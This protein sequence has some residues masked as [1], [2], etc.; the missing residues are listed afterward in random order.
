MPTD[1]REEGMNVEERL[2][3]CELIEAVIGADG[4]IADAERELLQRIVTRF[5]LPERPS[6]RPPPSD[7]GR[8]TTTL[9]SMALEDQPRVMALLVDAAVADGFVTPEERALLLASAATLGIEATALEDR[10][11][12]RL[13]SKSPGA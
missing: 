10:I 9:R 7:L 6:Q 5:G 1:R 3:V 4:V 11:A 8:T 13:R 2:K 12:W